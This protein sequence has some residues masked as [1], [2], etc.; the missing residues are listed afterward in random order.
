[1]INQPK[2]ET[3]KI[4]C[5]VIKCDIKGVQ[6]YSY[7]RVW[8][9]SDEGWR[10]RKKRL[11]VKKVI[12]DFVAMV[13]VDLLQNSVYTDGINS[14]FAMDKNKIRNVHTEVVEFKVPTELFLIY[15]VYSG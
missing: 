7:D 5:N 8:N 15:H 1:M 11:K 14:F 4:K 12:I 13:D 3:I 9:K 2:L 10:M 6:S